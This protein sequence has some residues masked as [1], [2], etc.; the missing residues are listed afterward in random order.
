[1]VSWFDILQV[2]MTSYQMAMRSP[3][4]NR[5]YAFSLNWGNAVPAHRTLM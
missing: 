1:V 2:L 5:D 3:A 4:F